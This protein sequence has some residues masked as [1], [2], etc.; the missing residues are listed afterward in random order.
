[1]KKAHWIAVWV[2]NLS[3]SA[4]LSAQSWPRH[5]LETQA[6]IEP[7]KVLAQV[8]PAIAEAKAQGNLV[9]VATLELARANACRVVADWDCQREAGLAAIGAAR[10]AEQPLLQVRG[11]IAAARGGFALRDYTPGEKLLGEAQLVLAKH[12]DSTLLADVFLAYSSLSYTLGKH[13][14]AGEYAQRGL[15][16]LDINS[17]PGMRARLYRNLARAEMQL[18]RRDAA[19]QTL[20]AGL[21]AAQQVKDPKL[22]AEMSL[23]RARLA[24]IEG[25]LD[26]QRQEGQRVLDL[27][28]SLKN[29]QLKGLG[30]EVLGLEASARG[31]LA[32]ARANLE[33]AY[34]SF[35]ELGL[36]RDE[37]RVA[38]D[39]LDL[40][41]GEIP[42]STR[43]L[44]TR[45]LDIDRAV[46]EADRAKAA[47]DYESRIDYA[48]QEL[49]VT[50]LANEAAMSRMRAE[51]ALQATRLTSLLML[52]ALATV[53]VLAALLII[54]RR[55]N[56]KTARLLEAIRSSDA[57][58]SELL[59]L[60]SGMVFLHDLEGKVQMVNP[61]TARA[62]GWNAEQLIDRSI[63][64]FISERERPLFKAFLT[65]LAVKGKDEGVVGVLTASGDMR[66]WRISCRLSESGLYAIGHAVDVTDEL[67]EREALREESHR[68]ALTGAYNRRYLDD[69]EALAQEQAW[70]VVGID[71]DHFKYVN[72]TQGHEAGD[73]ILV[74]LT[75][76]LES[77]VREGDA[78][79]RSGG[80]EFLLLLARCDE[81]KLQRVFDRLCSE[82]H[83]SPCAYSVG[84]ALRI[85]HEA[86]TE[87][88]ARADADMYARRKQQRRSRA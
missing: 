70:G 61:A 41:L 50:R 4:A 64:E 42:E 60:T 17:D 44:I 65:Q 71:L 10:Q 37:Q 7:D 24:R 38:R 30:M 55:A 77:H 22:V 80:D 83:L 62:L 47:D 39:L 5:A 31:D 26:V 81:L 68:D 35:R 33:S 66:R 74:A 85:D 46:E 49:E 3:I 75:R 54:S 57:R 21:S 25:D 87:T 72:D 79:V 16:L 2:L 9:D 53:L 28:E 14:S 12:P 43:A 34:H 69:F 23:E 56:N 27:G 45:Y 76:F 20:I 67:R 52:S 73:R 36:M 59:R 86:L 84:R 8:M 40:G 82:A 6:L 18:D 48:E 78:V 63:A 88:I 51:A 29:S 58:A 13:E 1:M 11:M 15:D 32:S 19:R